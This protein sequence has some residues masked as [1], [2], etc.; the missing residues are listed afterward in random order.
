M[1]HIDETTCEVTG[2]SR[3]QSGIR[4]TLTGTVG[5]DEV[6]EHGHTFLEVRENRV[7]DIGTG[8][9]RAGLERLTHDTTDTC[10][11]L[12]LVGVT[13]CTGV[14]H[15]IYRVESFVRLLHVLHDDTL[16]FLIDLFP[17]INGLAVALVVGNETVDVVE[18]DIIDNGITLGDLLF[19]LLRDD[20]II[21]V[22]G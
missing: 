13:T 6:L 8:V 1:R 2:I 12:D 15:H 7:L 20:D 11:L 17:S 14:H 9:G 10:E 3:L 16:E 4:Q 22:E 21:E 5:R 19:L 18:V